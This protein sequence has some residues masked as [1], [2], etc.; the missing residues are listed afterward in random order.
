M[1]FTSAA[2]SAVGLSVGDIKVNPMDVGARRRVRKWVPRPTEGGLILKKE[3]P[4]ALGSADQRPD[5][6]EVEPDR[7]CEE[8]NAVEPDVVDMEASSSGIE[9]PLPELAD[10]VERTPPGVERPSATPPEQMPDG[11]AE[12]LPPGSVAPRMPKLPEP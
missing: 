9:R 4:L 1:S 7:L 3:N 2:E 5:G 12:A 8:M 10:G 6:L 11:T